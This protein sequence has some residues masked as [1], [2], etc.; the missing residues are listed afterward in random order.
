ME[1]FNSYFRNIG[2]ENIYSERIFD[3]NWNIKQPNVLFNENY[4]KSYIS[5]IFNTPDGL[6][7]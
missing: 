7:L 2:V 5:S 3:M 6:S 4:E 1:T